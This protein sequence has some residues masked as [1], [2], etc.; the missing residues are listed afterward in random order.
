MEY[1][2]G[3]GFRE[4]VLAISAANLGQPMFEF[5]EF[6]V[7]QSLLC[8]LTVAFGL[9]VPLAEQLIVLPLQPV[10]FLLVGLDLRLLLGWFSQSAY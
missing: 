7:K 5:A 1:E 8:L 6:V 3:C 10:L 4:V 2:F 9:V